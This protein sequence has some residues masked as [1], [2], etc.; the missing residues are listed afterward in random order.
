MTQARSSINSSGTS[1][2]RF[3]VS[4]DGGEGTRW[5]WT[6][7]PRLKQPADPWITYGDRAVYYLTAGNHTFNIVPGY[8]SP[9]LTAIKL[10][11]DFSWKP[12]TYFW[13]GFGW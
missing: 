9:T 1:I 13:G 7:D 3:D 4:L 6:S 8:N 5:S 2:I 11:N 12:S 10:T